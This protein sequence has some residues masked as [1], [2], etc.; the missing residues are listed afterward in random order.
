MGVVC[1][2]ITY[3]KSAAMQF[4][5]LCANIYGLGLQLSK[6]EV[7]KKFYLGFLLS[8]RHFSRTSN[9]DR[10]QFCSPWSYDDEK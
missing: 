2:K 7:S 6:L 1:A 9:F 5:K 4:F 3:L 10:S 8:R